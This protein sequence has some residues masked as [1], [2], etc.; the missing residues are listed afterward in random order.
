MKIW[1]FRQEKEP[2]S[3]LIVLVQNVIQERALMSTFN[4]PASVHISKIKH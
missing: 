2:I 4:I 3:F 1:N